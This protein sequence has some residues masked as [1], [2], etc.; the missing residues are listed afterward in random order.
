[1]AEVPLSHRWAISNHCKRPWFIKNYHVMHFFF[2][3]EILIFVN[4]NCIWQIYILLNLWLCS[5]SVNSRQ[6][7]YVTAKTKIMQ[8]S[9]TYIVLHFKKFSDC[10]L[11]KWPIF[12]PYW[13]I[14]GA[15]LL[16]HELDWFLE[17]SSNLHI[18]NFGAWHRS[19]SGKLVQ[20][21][22]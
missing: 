16:L 20:Q 15:W 10:E 8:N 9:L 6:F 2:S 3:C 11:W 1:M 12:N 14:F 17:N 7:G 19:I 22:V 5:F 21:S 4:L 18:K 13:Q